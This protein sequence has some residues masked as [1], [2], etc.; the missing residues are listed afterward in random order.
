MVVFNLLIV[1]NSDSIFKAL[2]TNINYY[3][4]HY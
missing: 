3:Y 2:I 1:V 4:Y